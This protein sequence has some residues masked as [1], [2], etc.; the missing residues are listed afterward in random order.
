MLVEDSARWIE[1]A[2]GE[3]LVL[4]GPEL[5]LGLASVLPLR[6][7]RPALGCVEVPE[8]AEARW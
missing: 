8:G 6:E 1:A 7:R 2:D 5:R 4:V 3:L